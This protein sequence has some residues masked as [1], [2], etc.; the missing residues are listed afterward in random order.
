MAYLVIYGELPTPEQA[1][2]FCDRLV[3]EADVPDEI[4]RLFELM[5]KSTV[6]MDALRTGLSFLAGYEDPALLHDN[7]HEANLEKGIRLLAQTPTLVAN[8]YR[9][10]ND[11]PLVRPD[12]DLPYMENFLYMLRGERP[13]RGVVGRIRSHSHV[14]HRARDAEFYIRGAG[15]RFY[16]VGH[17]RRDGR[18]GGIA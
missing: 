8:S 1:R 4:Y 18:R 5:P 16:S 11:M 2:A 12:P 15:H 9:A 7:S 13:G 17:V 14:L 3:A 10:L 6:A